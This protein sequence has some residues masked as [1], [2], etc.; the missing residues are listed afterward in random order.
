MDCFKDGGYDVID[1]YLVDPR[2]VE[3]DAPRAKYYIKNFFDSQP[4]LNYGYAHP[5]PVH[6]WEQ[7]VDAPGPQTVQR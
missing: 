6:P 5:D 2:F 1:Y 4:A 7:P 3:A